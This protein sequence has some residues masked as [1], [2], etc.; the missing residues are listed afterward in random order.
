VSVR[1]YSKVS[2]IRRIPERGKGS[3]L[4][5]ELEAMTQDI[6]NLIEW[7]ELLK[8][9]VAIMQKQVP[10]ANRTLSESPIREFSS[11]NVKSSDT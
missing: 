4:A 6:D 8:R 9:R 3:D 2:V 5:G 10:V 1:R 7:L 11:Q